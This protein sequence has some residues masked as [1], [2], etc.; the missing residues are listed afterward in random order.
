MT[1][2]SAMTVRH[3][4][5]RLPTE[6]DIHVGVMIARRRLALG[7]WRT[8]LAR[9]LDIAPAMLGKY[10]Q[11]Q[12]RVAA[13]RLYDLAQALG[14]EVGYF[15]EGL[16]GGPDGEGRGSDSTQAVGKNWSATTETVS[17]ARAYSR[18]PGPKTRK[19]LLLLMRSIGSDDGEKPDN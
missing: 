1:N 14:V 4:L 7:M 17:A 12:S 16:S 3:R 10:E 18:I 19:S 15:F 8:E 6:V 11:G 9:Q 5:A 13:G 2:R